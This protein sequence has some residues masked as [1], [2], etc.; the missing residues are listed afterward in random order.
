MLLKELSAIVFSDRND[1]H[2][3]RLFD[4]CIDASEPSLR[5]IASSLSRTHR[6]SYTMRVPRVSVSAV[7]LAA[8]VPILAFR[9]G[10]HDCAPHFVEITGNKSAEVPE[11]IGRFEEIGHHYGHHASGRS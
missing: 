10:S 2:K 11:F 4:D 8:I 3:V 6:F 1:H 7:S 5:R 9:A